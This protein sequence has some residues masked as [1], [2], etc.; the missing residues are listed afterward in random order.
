MILFAIV[1]FC[2]PGKQ[3]T[4][5][6]IPSLLLL[7]PAYDG[8]D[9]MLSVLIWAVGERGPRLRWNDFQMRQIYR[10]PDI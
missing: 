3:M 6:P 1:L 5:L 8:G 2:E 10:N 4:F 7:R 9:V